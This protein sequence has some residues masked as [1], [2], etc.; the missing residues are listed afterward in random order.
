SGGWTIKLIDEDRARASTDMAQ[1]VWPGSN[2]GPRQLGRDR[3]IAVLA[4]FAPLQSLVVLVG[5]NPPFAGAVKPAGKRKIAGLHRRINSVMDRRTFIGNI[6]SGILA[7]PLA[8][9]AQ[10]SA[11]PV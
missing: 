5:Q 7:V 11:I 1:R 8:A 4:D 9:Q 2:R 3:P 10:Q 6:A